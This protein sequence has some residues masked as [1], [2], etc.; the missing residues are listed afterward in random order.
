MVA[1]KFYKIIRVRVPSTLIVILHFL[2]FYLPEE[3]RAVSSSPL[4][5]DS[6]SLIASSF[7]SLDGGGGGGGGMELMSSFEV[8][9]TI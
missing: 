1:N 5:F 7:M 9:T 6:G 4:L 8:E 3:L 2:V